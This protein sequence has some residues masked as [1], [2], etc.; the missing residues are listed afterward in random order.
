MFSKS[1]IFLKTGWRTCPQNVSGMAPRF[2]STFSLCARNAM[3]AFKLFEVHRRGYKPDTALCNWG[4]GESRTL[5]ATSISGSN[6]IRITM[7]WSGP[8]IGAWPKY[9]T[10]C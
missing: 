2:R 6:Q 7:L 5:A 8:G 1:L 9:K 4:G 3:L 10:R